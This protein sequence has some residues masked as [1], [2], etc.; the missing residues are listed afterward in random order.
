[1]AL[2]PNEQAAYSKLWNFVSAVAPDRT[3]TGSYTYTSSDILSAA[4]SI[5]RE[6]GQS[7]SFAESSGIFGLISLARGQANAIDALN[8][9]APNQAID[10]SMIAQWPTAADAE[11][12]AVQPSYMAKGQF[13]YTDAL[14]QQ[15]SAWVTLTGLTGIPVSADALALRL[16]GAAIQAYT[17]PESEGGNYLPAEQMSTFGEITSMQLYA[18]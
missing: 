6:A 10:A 4:A 17:T 2:T 7:L 15:Q 16:T 12:Q 9:A 14:G 5:A 1:V 18:V 11:V 13:T 3:D 8:S